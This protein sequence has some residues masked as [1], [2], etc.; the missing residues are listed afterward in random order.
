MERVT[1]LNDKSVKLEKKKKT[2]SKIK[3]KLEELS[4]KKDSYKESFEKQEHELEDLM[5][6]ICADHHKNLTDK[7][8]AKDE[9][10]I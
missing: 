4:D 9:Y 3:E 10:K 6:K 1:R 8:D 5:K 2:F 7:L